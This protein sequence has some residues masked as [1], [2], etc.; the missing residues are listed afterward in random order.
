MNV[1]IVASASEELSTS[2]TEIS[3]QVLNSKTI[4]VQA[5]ETS[6]MATESIQNLSQMAQK[7]GDVI[8]LIN[9]ITEQTNL[10][11]LNVTI[12]A[13]RAGAAGSGFA[14]VASEVK[15]LANQTAN[16]TPEILGKNQQYAICHGT[17]R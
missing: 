16:T 7:V 3:Q 4:T 13:P 12:E 5:Q 1:Q 6:N 9:D 17:F 10:L 2:I 14:V 11:A 8:N 15:K